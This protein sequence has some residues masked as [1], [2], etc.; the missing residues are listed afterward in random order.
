[1]RRVR[2]LLGSDLHDAPLFGSRARRGTRVLGHRYRARR[3]P[4][5]QARRHEVCGVAFDVGL[6]YRV[7]LAPVVLER[8]RFEFLKARERRIAHDIEREGVPP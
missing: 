2:A 4:A 1:M 6:E 5:G 8:E 7:N 3:Y